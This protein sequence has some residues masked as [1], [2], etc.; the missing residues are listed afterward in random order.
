MGKVT[1]TAFDSSHPSVAIAYFCGMAGLTMFCMQPVLAAISLAG[2]L[3]FGACLRGAPAT[4]CGLRWQLPMVAVVA[5]ANPLF[6]ASG[7]TLLFKVGPMAIYLE[8]V[9]YG[10]CAGCVL[11]AAIMWL[12]CAAEVVTQDRLLAV[13]GSRVPVV[14]LMV[15]MTARL[16]PQLVRR[17]NLVASVDR[18][19]T[20]A[21]ADGGVVPASGRGLRG[22]RSR[23]ASAATVSGALVGWSLSDSLDAADSMRARGWGAVPD[24]SSYQP[25]TF[26]SSDAWALAL[27]VCLVG[28]CALLGWVACSQYRFYP[29][30]SV[31][32]PWWGYAP[33]AL[34]SLL[35]SILHAKEAISWRS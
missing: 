33:Y 4:L 17:G 19:V 28:L 22:L 29:T 7:S 30:M 25:W 2:A 27:V 24:R 26:R 23:V 13:A 18:V 34:L 32:L 3:L 14:A 10:A 15:S 11:A 35:P 8:S 21:D 20:G 12:S 5:L 31:L 6:S 1:H 16:V 9:C